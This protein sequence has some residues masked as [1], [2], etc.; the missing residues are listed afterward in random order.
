MTLMTL[1]TNDTIQ[2]SAHADTYT[3]SG[4][5]KQPATHS[6]CIQSAHYPTVRRN[7]AS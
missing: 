4:R 3:Q 6:P 7:P 5:D 1:Y 2:C